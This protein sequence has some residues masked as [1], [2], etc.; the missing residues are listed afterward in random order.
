L[1]VLHQAG[2]NVLDGASYTYDPA[3][4]R[5]S[6]TNYLNGVT[7]NYTYDPLYELTQVTQA[8]STTES[9]SYEAA[10]NRLSSL[11]M[12]SYQY[13][14]SNELTVSSAGSYTYDNNGNTL[15]DAQGRSFTWDIEN[16][17]TQAVNPGIGTTTFRYDPFGRRIQKYSPLGVTNYVYDR[18]NLLTEI[19][20]AGNLFLRYT[21]GASVDEPLSELS[22]GASSFY[23]LDGLGSV[24]SLSVATGVLANKYSYDS[25]G[26]VTTLGGTLSNELQFTGREFDHET[27]LEYYRARYYDPI[28]G[29]FTN[30]DPGAFDLKSPNLYLYVTNSPIDLVDPSGLAPQP[31]GPYIC[32]LCSEWGQ[33]FLWMWEGYER[34]RDL[35]WR[36]SDKYFHCMANCRA[37]NAG[38]GGVAAAKIL[39]FFRTDVR[40]RWTEPTDWRNDAAANKCGQKGGNCEQTCAPFFPRSSPGNPPFPGWPNQ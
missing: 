34:M 38:W 26:K 23:E 11:G 31:M 15:T 3:G 8:G 25:F 35:K 17:L 22:A 36:N 32:T 21:Q 20:N 40:S 5:N 4:N 24:T 10:G 16:R 30:E 1:S 27:G 9:Y 19:D 28:I 37:T 39:S 6:K 18:M 29:R 2:T 14:A 7:E 12:P 13:N 33:G